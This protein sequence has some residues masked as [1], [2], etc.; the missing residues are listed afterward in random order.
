LCRYEQRLLSQTNFDADR[1]RRDRDKDDLIRS[2]QNEVAMWKTK[3][4]N[5][6]KMYAQLRKEHLELLNKYK[7]I[8]RQATT[9]KEA[10]VEKEK[11]A[12]MVKSKNSELSELMKEKEMWKNALEKAKEETTEEITRLRREAADSKAR[13]EEL[14]NS[15]G[16]ETQNLVAKFNS[17]KSE[18]EARLKAQFDENELV[19]ASMRELKSE[20]EKMKMEFEQKN[21]EVAVL[22]AGMDQSLMALSQIQQRG[23]DTEADLMSKMDGLHL[24]HR[25]QMDK[26]MGTPFSA[27]LH[28]CLSIR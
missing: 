10:H 1:E 6:A 24:E 19:K 25:S 8:Q 22:Q 26:I 16:A 13:F 11:L 18:Q 17:E 28:F 2:L 7:D 21:E 15:K 3:Y 12:T 27:F 23:S 20:L 4:E 9:A 14:T 5:I